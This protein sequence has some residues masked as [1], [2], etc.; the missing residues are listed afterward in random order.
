[1]ESKFQEFNSWEIQNFG[2]MVQQKKKIV[3]YSILLTGESSYSEVFD[4]R[5]LMSEKFQ[6]LFLKMEN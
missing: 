5:S 3:F 1:M 2:K 4:H 6:Q